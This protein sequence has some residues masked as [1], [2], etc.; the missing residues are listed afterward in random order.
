MHY[1]L[2]VKKDDSL[3]LLAH[4]INVT[5]IVLTQQPFQPWTA[6]DLL[7]KNR[8]ELIKETRRLIYIN[9]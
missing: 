4:S 8:T 1:R 6:H 9:I 5:P 2:T 7:I 3:D